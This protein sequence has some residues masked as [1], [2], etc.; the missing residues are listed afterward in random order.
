MDT[1]KHGTLLIGIAILISFI[2]ILNYNYIMEINW[3]R[4]G[5]LGIFLVM[6]LSSASVFFP[7]PGMAIVTFAG[8]FGDPILIGVVGGLGACVGELT[9]YLFGYGSYE[10]INSPKYKKTIKKIKETKAVFP[11]IF[12]FAL[13]PNPL[14]DLVGVSAGALKY[15]VL[16][17]LL[18]AF[19]GNAIK[20]F[21]FAYIG[22]NI[23]ELLLTLF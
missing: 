17:F 15:P 4:W 8:A 2:L 20:I 13:L 18:A 11:L 9:G 12:T 23:Y 14:F 6:L 5:Y 7:L 21:L 10:I 3:L 1:K 16:K 19:L 22:D